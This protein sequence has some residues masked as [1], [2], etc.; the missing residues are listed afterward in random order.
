MEFC[1]GSYVIKCVCTCHEI[2][3]LVLLENFITVTQRLAFPGSASCERFRKECDDN[4][5]ATHQPLQ[6]IG[7]AI[8]AL[9]AEVRSSVADLWFRK[10]KTGE[11][12]EDQDQKLKT[13]CSNR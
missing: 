6:R 7:V 10:D 1:E 3:D 4:S 2:C 5:A 12:E 11:R 9:Q 8:R 13:H